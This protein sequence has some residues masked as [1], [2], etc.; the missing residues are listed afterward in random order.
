MAT[1]SA[2]SISSDDA[3][4]LLSASGV[5]KRFGGVHAL[6]GADLEVRSGTVAVLIGRSGS[7]KTT[8]LRSLNGLEIP[9]AGTVRIGDV[10]V[11]YGAKPTK[12]ELILLRAQSSMVFQAH[13]LFPHLSVL[14]N[15]TEGPVIAQRRP[16]QG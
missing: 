13:N 9:D 15:V 10:A 3:S 14:R 11:D 6:R 16:Q 8:V 4:M 1:T 2:P 12:K 5:H 7:G